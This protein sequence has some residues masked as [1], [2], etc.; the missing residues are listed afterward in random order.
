M[1]IQK[2]KQFLK[3]PLFYIQLKLPLQNLQKTKDKTVR[4]TEKLPLQKFKKV[5]KY[6]LLQIYK[7]VKQI[8]NKK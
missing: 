1:D 6:F 8:D 2:S 4:K 5:L 7:K 3:M